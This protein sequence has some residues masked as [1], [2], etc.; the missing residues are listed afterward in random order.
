V[1]AKAPG[2]MSLMGSARVTYTFLYTN[3]LL[4]PGQQRR[5]DWFS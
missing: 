5:R 4:D 3:Y 1:S 2:Q